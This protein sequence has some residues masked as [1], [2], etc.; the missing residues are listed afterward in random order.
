MH[1]TARTGVVRSGGGTWN[2]GEFERDIFRHILAD[3]T[4]LARCTRHHH[5]SSAAVHHIQPARPSAKG[6]DWGNAG[7]VT[8][9]GI[10]F[11]AV[12]MTVLSRLVILR[13]GI[14]LCGLC[15]VT[16]QEHMHDNLACAKRRP[17]FSAK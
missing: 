2:K 8:V 11:E 5:I 14:S 1:A 15:C 9:R 4:F 7:V 6:V 10:D 13:E 16:R 3:S 17:C 12:E